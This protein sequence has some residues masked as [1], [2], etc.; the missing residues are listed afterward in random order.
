MRQAVHVRQTCTAGN[1]SMLICDCRQ[2][3]PIWSA[4]CA[5]T[6]EVLLCQLEATAGPFPE[7]VTTV[8]THKMR[9]Q[10]HEGILMM[11][12]AMHVRQICT[13]GNASMLICDCRQHK[14]DQ[15]SKPDI[16]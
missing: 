14:P 11:R 6:D 3:K 4:A 9:R 10:E 13:A 12:Q 8:V 2:H 15:Q 7:E 16:L 1:A 5:Q